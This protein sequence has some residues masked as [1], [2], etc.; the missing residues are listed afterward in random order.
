MHLNETLINDK[1]IASNI[2]NLIM[3]P[4]LKKLEGHIAFGLCVCVC[5]CVCVC[6]CVGGWVGGCVC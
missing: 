5:V 3:P 2:N 4:T 6:G 1:K